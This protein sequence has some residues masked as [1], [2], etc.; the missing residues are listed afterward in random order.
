[1]LSF[2]RSNVLLFGLL[3]LLQNGLKGHFERLKVKLEKQKWTNKKPG[4]ELWV[5]TSLTG[6]KPLT[7]LENKM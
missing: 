1:M 4:P 5:L 7:Q 3:G 6:L 2:Y